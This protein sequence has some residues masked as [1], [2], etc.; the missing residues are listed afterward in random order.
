M[1][2]NSIVDHAKFMRSAERFPDH[3]HRV[4]ESRLQA[5]TQQSYS[6]LFTHTM[7]LPD[8]KFKVPSLVQ[9]CQRV[10]TAHVDSISSVGDELRYDLLKP[11][12][13]RCTVEQLSR[14]EEASP[15]LVNE[16][17]EIWKD[18]CL[19]KY[20]AAAERY[21]SA[22]LEEPVSWKEQYFFW[23]RK[24]LGDLRKLVLSFGG[25][26]RKPMNERRSPKSNSRRSAPQAGSRGM[27]ARVEPKTLF[28]KTRSEASR[29]H[30]NK[31]SRPMIPPMPGSKTFRVLSSSHTDLLPAARPETRRVTVT[32]VTQRVPATGA[33]LQTASPMPRRS[34]PANGAFIS[35][36]GSQNGGKQ[37]VPV[38][39][40]LPSISR[41]LPAPT[42]TSSQPSPAKR[43]KASPSPAPADLP[44]AISP[45]KRD[46]M[47]ALFMPK[48]RA[49]SQRAK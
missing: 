27:P 35:S 25:K 19:Q 36:A 40:P 49:Y 10:A 6:V 9:Y 42:D 28:Q 43:R 13:Q 41:A 2:P 46:P 15:R 3:N 33:T 26:N 31:Y 34:L 44:K 30:K 11:I 17:P 1:L 38:K 32:T 23:S 45:V 18:L 12:L 7:T 22:S 5:V 48:H 16:T 4:L 37:S 24:M 21:Q 8:D 14:F 20:S 47:A 29:L 39:V